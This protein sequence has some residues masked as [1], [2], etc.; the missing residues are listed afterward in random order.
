VWSSNANPR[1][2]IADQSSERRQCGLRRDTTCGRNTRT[3]RVTTFA[4]STSSLTER[5]PSRSC[6]LVSRCSCNRTSPR[7]V[8]NGSCQRTPRR[9][10]STETACCRTTK[11]WH[12]IRC[13]WS[14]RHSVFAGR[15]G[16]RF[17]ER[18]LECSTS[19]LRT[20]PQSPKLAGDRPPVQRS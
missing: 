5:T 13:T 9:F 19:P 18:C 6:S 8:R 15:R 12:P 11:V 17:R 16:Y 10:H 7:E 14:R 4:P 2:P 20:Q 1:K 3:G